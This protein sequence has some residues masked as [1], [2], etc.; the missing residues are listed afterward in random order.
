MKRRVQTIWAILTSLMIA[1]T[2]CRPQ[3]PFYLR[4]DGDLSHYLDVAT[5]LEYPD[6]ET[7]T[8]DEVTQ[9]LPPYTLENIEFADYWDLTLEEAIQTALQNSKVFRSLGGRFV[10]SAFNN[11]SQTGEAPDAL[12]LS[13]DQ[14]RTIYDPAIVETTPF[15]GVEYALSAFDTQWST[16]YFYSHNDRQQNV[17]PGQAENFFPPVFQQN[18]STFNTQLSKITATG[19]QF[20]VRNNIV[21]DL[22]N[23]PTRQVP[24]DWNVNYEV[25]FNQPL[26]AGAGVEYNRIAGP[27]S[28]FLQVVAGGAPTSLQFDGVVLARINVDI[29]LAD[30]E[31]AVRNLVNDTEQAYWELSFAWRNLETANTALNS[32]RQTWE[33]IYALF[34]TG[35]RGGEANAEAQAR[36]QF[37]QFKSQAQTLLNELFR[38]ENRLRSIMGLS[39]TDG[40]LVRPTD[41]PSIAKVDFDWCEIVEEALAR[42]LDL[43]RQKWR[44][45]QRELEIVASKNLLMP[46][47]DM[48]GTYRWQGLGD[49]LFGTRDSA[50]NPNVPGSLTG[51]SALQT[52]ATGQFQEWQLGLQSTM[53][54]GF[55]RELTQLRHFQLQLARERALL[56]DQEL[57]ISHQLADAERQLI[58]NY[59]LTQTNF[60]RTLAADKQV[61]AQQAAYESGTVTLDQLLEAQRRRAEA[62]ASFFRTLIDYQRAIVTMHYRKGSLLE[63]NSVYLAEG[64]WPEKA[65]FDAHRLARQ[66]DAGIYMNYGYTRPS[67]ISQGPVRQNA[68]GVPPEL[69]PEG[70]PSEAMPE[71]LPAGEV[72]E[73]LPEPEYD[74]NASNVDVSHVM[75]EAPR[76]Q[77]TKKSGGQ[78]EWGGL[79]LDEK[80]SPAEP[81]TSAKGQADD[82]WS[83]IVGQGDDARRPTRSVLKQ[84]RSTKA[85]SG[86]APSAPSAARLPGAVR[87]AGV[88]QAAHQ[89]QP[90]WKS[91]LKNEAVPHQSPDTSAWSAANKQGA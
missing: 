67:V 32:A 16:N 71:E 13:P 24:K 58:L 77:T 15:N 30:F 10:S 60:N 28:P 89:A 37:Y 11:R 81:K 7:T 59:E 21:Y 18:T 64:P 51:S 66:R 27:F 88:K 74:Y 84:P 34:R 83:R 70:L 23:N 62:Q 65:E 54:I 39:V 20:T 47:L 56:Q 79:G 29:S 90:P 44:I 2:G 19:G 76:P 61:E 91:T 1:L 86:D 42:N 3:Q 75:G 17:A 73:T 6:V 40:R 46:R 85:T 14:T 25:S 26:L 63:Y 22:N 35:S 43:R 53:T 12:T 33:K 8:L 69:L 80:A 72:E 45:K 41:R 5:N 82:T 52:L 9:S 49:D 36:E 38:A 57:E 48:T 31:G 87:D 55:R 78:F 4:E 50:F 68:E